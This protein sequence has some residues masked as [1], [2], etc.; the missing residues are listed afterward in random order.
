MEMEVPVEELMPAIDSILLDPDFREPVA[1]DFDLFSMKFEAVNADPHVEAKRMLLEGL[2]DQKTLPASIVPA[3]EYAKKDLDE[4]VR[5]RAIHCLS[6]VSESD[7]NKI[8][9]LIT[10]LK[11][12][13]GY[14]R[15]TAINLLGSMKPVPREAVPDLIAAAKD[16]DT[17][18]RVSAVKSLGNTKPV[19]LEVIQLLIGALK[20]KKTDVRQAAADAF[21]VVGEDGKEAIPVLRQVSETDK[22]TFVR[23]AAKRAL[24]KMGEK[25]E[26]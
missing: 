22:D 8:A 24:S 7:D 17:D 16:K 5:S 12:A 14:D 21:E 6:K 15:I 20:D 1:Y 23:S 13:K 4:S 10:S 18:V 19:S 3:L 26:W 2:D 25:V 9:R 11:T